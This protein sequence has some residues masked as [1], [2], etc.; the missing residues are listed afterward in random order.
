MTLKVENAAGKALTASLVSKIVSMLGPIVLIPLF[1]IKSCV[2]FWDQNGVVGWRFIHL[3]FYYYLISFW[4]FVSF[5]GF[6]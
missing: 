4:I 1:I 3:Y 6:L 2:L 5:I